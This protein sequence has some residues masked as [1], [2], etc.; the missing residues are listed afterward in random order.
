M[1]A[2]YAGSP[3]DPLRQDGELMAMN[4]E[5]DEWRHSVRDMTEVQRMAACGHTSRIHGLCP[6]CGDRIDRSDV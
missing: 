6:D 4:H 3:E 2:V 5:L 1:Q